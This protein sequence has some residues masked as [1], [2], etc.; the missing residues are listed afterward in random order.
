MTRIQEYMIEKSFTDQCKKANVK[1]TR[2]QASKFLRGKGAAYSICILKLPVHIPPH[3][4]H[5]DENGNI[6]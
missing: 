2:T 3:A 5:H 1:P 6:L 4:R